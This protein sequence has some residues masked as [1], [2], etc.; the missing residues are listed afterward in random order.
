MEKD[1]LDL[2]VLKAFKYHHKQKRKF[3]DEPYVYHCLRVGS[4]VGDYADDNEDLVIAGVLHDIVEDTEVTIEDIGRWFSPEVQKL[5][6]ELTNDMKILRKMG[7]RD[8]MFDKFS[9]ISDGALIVKSLDRLDNLTGLINST[10]PFK[11]IQT[12]VNDTDFILENLDRELLPVHKTLF[13]NLGF[14]NNYIALTV[15]R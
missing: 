14:I 1:L 13:H 11:F 6:Y 3:C 12:Y 8:Y 15:L 10:A 9:S 4:L 5:V 7:K 2:A